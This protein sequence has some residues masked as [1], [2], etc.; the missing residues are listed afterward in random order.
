M[1]GVPLAEGAGRDRELRR[2]ITYLMLYRVVLITLV[3]GLTVALNAASQLE[4]TA[5]STLSLFAIIIVTYVL[6]LVYAAILPRVANALRFADA[7][8]LGDLLITTVL[9][10]VSG[11]AQSGYTFFYPLSI[12]GAA[13]VRYRRGAVV[14]AV[15]SVLLLVT[16]ATLG[17]L[18]ALPV[19]AGLRLLPWDLSA[20]GLVRQL[21]LNVGACVGI[22]FLASNL[23]EQLARSGERLQT[24]L[25]RSA[26][27]A[28]INE[29]IIRCLSSGLLTID[30]QGTIITYNQA[31]EE[32]LGT[33]AGEAIGRPIAALVPEM[34]PL[35]ERLGRD[36][37]LRRG[38]VATGKR[39]LG[40]SVSP[41]ANHQDRTIG[42]IVNFQDL[43]ELR[44]LEVQMRRAERLAVIGGVAAGV[45]HEIRNPL[46]AISG[47][48][49]LLRGAAPAEGEN[50][51][52]YD[53]VLREVDRLN[54][55]VSDLLDYARPRARVPIAM[56]LVPLLEETVRVFGQDRSHANVRVVLRPS[57]T[58]D[59]IRLDAD[60]AQLR[61]VVW[62]LLR[63][64]AEA[65][66]EGGEATVSMRLV[67]DDG[68][69][70]LAVT[71]TGVGIPADELD[72]IFEPFYTTKSR[73]SGLGLATVQRIVVEH[74]GTIAVASTVGKGT[75][76]TVRIPVERAPQASAEA[77]LAAQEERGATSLARWK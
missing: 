13:T 44:R 47:S 17:W 36:E 70:E 22:G 34:A 61:Q 74:G 65:M 39:A 30:L 52:L 2:R 31:A 28:A 46:A 59:G 73:G 7:Q 72:K 49:E 23:G 8:L 71:D 20:L 42:R 6:T 56:D 77:A 63:N 43:T 32:I 53:I 76:F 68:W 10:H 5:P 75:T 66:P 9:V 62:N 26:D 21:L 50:R 14:V 60:P 18:R 67:D 35:L 24:Q 64:G 25:T 15:A 57:G 1:T 55:L 19:P 38:E 45:A 27:L 12:V 11:G 48:I 51:A 4:L 69:A 58:A 3:L 29:N 40:V 33:P 41:L 37:E 16:V 54:G